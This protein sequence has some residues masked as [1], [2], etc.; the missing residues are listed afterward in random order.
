[1]QKGKNAQMGVFTIRE[2]E[3]TNE[4]PLT[5]FQFSV[6]KPKIISTWAVFDVA[7]GKFVEKLVKY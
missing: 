5:T 1:M 3:R 6:E 2:A 7:S 4:Y